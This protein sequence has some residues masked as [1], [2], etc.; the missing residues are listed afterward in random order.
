MEILVFSKEL[1]I[2]LPC[3]LLFGEVVFVF[4]ELV[5]TLTVEALLGAKA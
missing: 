2:C 1:T 4:N 3:H 5:F